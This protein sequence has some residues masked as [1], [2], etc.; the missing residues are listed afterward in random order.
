M[1]STMKTKINSLIL[2]IVTLFT[3]VSCGQ[4]TENQKI[5]KKM[6]EEKVNMEAMETITFG[7]GC[8]WCVEAVFQQVEGVV[9]VESGYSNGQANKPS[10]R[11]VCTGNTGCAEVVQVTFDPKKVSFDTILEI[12]WKTHD[13]TTLNRQGAD[14]GTQYRSGVFYHNEAQKTAAEAWKK[15]LND[16]HVFPNPIVTEITAL[17]SY[18]PAEDYHQDYYALN[19]HN[20]YCQVVIK[21]KMDKLQKIF[22]DKLKK[23]AN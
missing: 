11:E 14:E 15:K 16:E 6:N 3:S 18:S 22:K 17:S 8:F 9:K 1:L 4:K 7:A 23:E 12:F 13:P 2:G 19:G 20:P 10:Y 21:P 5:N